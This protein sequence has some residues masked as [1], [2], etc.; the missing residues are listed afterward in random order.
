MGPTNERLKA[1]RRLLDAAVL[2][3]LS[4]PV[5]PPMNTSSADGSN[6]Q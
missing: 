6:I 4:F 3:R 1:A 5:D 2:R